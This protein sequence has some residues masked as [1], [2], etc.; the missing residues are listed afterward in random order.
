M[1][2]KE[3][4]VK[5]QVC[6]HPNALKYTIKYKNKRTE[7]IRDDETG[8][9]VIEV[10]KFRKDMGSDGGFFAYHN[11]E[12]GIVRGG[13]RLKNETIKDIMQALIFMHKRGEL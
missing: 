9:V 10:R 5:V 1:T 4:A 13:I 8:D 3:E 11:E 12:N 6:R 2:P 7:I